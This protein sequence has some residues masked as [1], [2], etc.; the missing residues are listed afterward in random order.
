MNVAN[1]HLSTRLTE[2]EIGE[3]FRSLQPDWQPGAKVN[4]GLLKVAYDR[5]NR[6]YPDAFD[7]YYRFVDFTRRMRQP[8][9]NKDGGNGAGN[10]RGNGRAAA[11]DDV[12]HAAHGDAGRQEA[13]LALKEVRDAMWQLDAHVAEQTALL[14]EV[15]GRIAQRL[16]IWTGPPETPAA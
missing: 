11:Q 15:S 7:T 16:E 14:R 2:L 9:F 10:G 13:I 12:D 3:I 6:Q 4:V 8:S 1:N 5:F